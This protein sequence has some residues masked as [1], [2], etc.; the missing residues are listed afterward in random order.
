MVVKIRKFEHSD[1]PRKVEWINNPMNNKFLHYDLPLSIE[2]TEKWFESHRGDT[3]RFDAVIEVDGVP[4]GTIGL[5]NID[6]QN[7]KAELYIAL[8]VEA[9]KGKGV[10][11][12]ASKLMLKYGFMTL[13]LHR[14]YLYTETGNLPAQRMFERIGFLKEGLLRQDVV[15]HGHIA[16]RYVYAILKED[17]NE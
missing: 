11:T 6:H 9:N 10:G 1:I 7:G 17:W 2:R 16:D 4:T 14:I 12:A 8:G 3:T 13:G 15:S 5:L